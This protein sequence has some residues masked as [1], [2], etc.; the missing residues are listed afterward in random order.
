MACQKKSASCHRFTTPRIEHQHAEKKSE[1]FKEKLCHAVSETFSVIGEELPSSDDINHQKDHARGVSEFLKELLE[2]VF[3][4][5]PELT[6]GS[7]TIYYGSIPINI[8]ITLHNFSVR[9]C[10]CTAYLK[11]QLTLNFQ[12]GFIFLKNEI[13]FFEKMYVML[14]SLFENGEFFSSDDFNLKDYAADRVEFLIKSLFDYAL[15]KLFDG[16]FTIY[17]GPIPIEI[18][19]TPPNISIA[20]PFPR[21]E[22]LKV[23]LKLN[24]QLNISKCSC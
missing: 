1:H 8:E 2:H 16:S 19:I 3:K 6:I 23:Q 11:L 17:C 18:R 14:E 20:V 22:N 24:F 15:K 12:F 10:S 9:I 13:I 4:M 5:L 21:S 7:H